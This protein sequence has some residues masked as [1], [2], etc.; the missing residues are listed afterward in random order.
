MQTQPM[1]K[2]LNATEKFTVTWANSLRCPQCIEGGFIFCKKSEYYN[3]TA[4]FPPVCCKDSTTANCPQINNSTFYDCSNIYSSA[5][6]AKQLC[7]L[8]T[9]EGG[10]NCGNSDIVLSDVGSQSSFTG[11][12]TVGQTCA[13]KILAKCGFPSVSLTPLTSTN[14]TMKMEVIDF[15]LSD[16]QG[17]SGAPQST[18]T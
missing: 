7:T 12:I 6:L 1:F 13:Y 5:S 14:A 11:N 3:G 18:S 2:A 10:A 16:L 4:N 17:T 8:S 9:S 15:Q